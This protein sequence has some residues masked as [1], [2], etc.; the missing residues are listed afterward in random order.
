MTARVATPAEALLGLLG[1]GRLLLPRG[2]K[3]GRATGRAAVNRFALYAAR[4]GLGFD[5]EEVLVRSITGWR[6]LRLT[7]PGEGERSDYR[8]TASRDAEI[9]A[10]ELQARLPGY[11]ARPHFVVDLRFWGEHSRF[12][13]T[14]LIRQTAVT[15]STLRRY[16]SDRHLTLVNAPPEARERFARA[17]P[18]FEG[19][20]SDWETLLSRLGEDRVVLLDPNA[21]EELTE[22]DLR[23]YDVFALGGIVDD[24]MQGWTEKLAPGIPADVIRRKITLR[25]RVEGV[26]DRVNALV[27][28]LC[29][30]LVEGESLREAVLSVQSPRFARR[31]LR[32]ELKGLDRLDREALESVREV[33]NLPPSEIVKEARRLGI[34]V[35]VDLQDG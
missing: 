15:A 13:R 8:T 3:T 7:V 35:E 6:G 33:V 23:R 18:T 19:G 20:F 32:L 17:F 4:K 30:V 31:R 10:E 1:R 21:E 12:G 28:A 29:R 5:P 25:G 34:P 26:P 27:E 14:N 22:R 16:L 24:N 11:P 9:P 2:Y